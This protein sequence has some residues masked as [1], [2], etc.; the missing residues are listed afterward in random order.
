[1]TEEMAINILE[2]LRNGEMEEYLIAKDEFL[3]FR[4]VLI[5]QEDFKHF[6]GIA[7]IGGDVLYQYFKEPIS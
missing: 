6:R 3:S 1:M 5:K 4:Q 2:K 7:Q